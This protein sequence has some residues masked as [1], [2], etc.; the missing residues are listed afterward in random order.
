METLP[1]PIIND[2]IMWG[3]LGLQVVIIVLAFFAFGPQRWTPTWLSRNAL[4]FA[5]LLV[6][7]S[8]IGSLYYSSIA[9]FAPCVLCWY[10]RIF[11]VAQIVVLGVA[12]HR[13][14]GK[15]A[16]PYAVALAVVG[17][18]IAVYHNILPFFEESYVCAPGEVS[19]LAE[20]VTGFGYIDIPMMS[21][22][23]FITTLLLYRLAHRGMLR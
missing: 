13:G 7:S 5:F 3:T 6:L 17:A 4:V 1:L 21:I 12:I 2:L 18:A 20:Y 23:A 11:V 15:T 9:G 14:E 8:F 16:L 19:C 10:Q 22:I